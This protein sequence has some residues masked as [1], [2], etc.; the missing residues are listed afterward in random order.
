MLSAADRKLLADAEA[1]RSKLVAAGHWALR[2]DA[3][4]QAELSRI[5][6]N[7]SLTDTVQDLHDLLGFWHAHG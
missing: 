7:S 3:D 4:A 2:S 5:A 1:L 6:K